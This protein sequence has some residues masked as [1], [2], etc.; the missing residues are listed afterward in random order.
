MIRYVLIVV[1]ATALLALSIPA[2]QYAATE[3]AEGQVAAEI[4]EIETASV[5]LVD[6]EELPPAGHPRPQRTITVSLPGSS[7]TTQPVDTFE[8]D[9]IA[10]HRSR[11]T[12]L[13]EGRSERQVLVDAPI[14][15]ENREENR[16]VEIGGSG[17]TDLTLVLEADPNDVPIVVVTRDRVP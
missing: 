9:R 12:F 16:T 4:T 3:N 17:D 14:V 15:Y 10:D 13:V 11:V 7:L 1:L 5:S 2:I 6:N 8:I